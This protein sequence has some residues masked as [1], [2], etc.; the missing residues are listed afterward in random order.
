MTSRP[1]PGQ[2]RPREI[3]REE[4]PRRRIESCGLTWKVMV[5]KWSFSMVGI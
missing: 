5:R 1:V 3:A 4:T 2:I